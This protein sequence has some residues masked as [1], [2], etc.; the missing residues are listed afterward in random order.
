MTDLN[1]I[2]QHP[3]VLEV[4]GA[5]KGQPRN[6]CFDSGKVSKGDMFVA[7]QGT[8]VDGHKYI[9]SAIKS[10]AAFVVCE[11]FPESVHSGICYIRVKDSHE[12]LGILASEFYGNPSTE[13]KIVGVTGTNGKTTIASLLYEIFRSLGYCAGLISTIKVSVNGKDRD[14]SH[15]TPDSLQLQSSLREMA[16]SGCEYVFMEVSSHAIHQKRIAGLSFEG[17]IF[18]NLSHEHLDYHKD[19]AGYRDAK[20]AFFDQLGESSFALSNKDDKNGEW[21]L[22]N[23]SAR[24]YTYSLKADSDF[25]G[26]ITE[27]HLEGNL[28]EIDGNEVW[29]RLPGR[30]NGANLLAVYGAA[31]LLGIENNE[32]LRALSEVSPVEGRFE[33]IISDKGPKAIVDYAHTPDALE[34]VLKTIIEINPAERIIT[35]VGAGGNRDKTK[36][37]EMAKIAAELSY[38]LILTSDNPR[39]EDPHEIIEDMK[40]GLDP[41]LMKKVLAIADRREAIKTACSFA[42]KDDI[43]LIAGKGHESYQEIKGQKHHFDDKEIIREFLNI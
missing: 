20:K 24:K 13:L 7:V 38:R 25:K 15:T 10:G 19:F 17:G 4:K 1:K 31:I 37:P 23:T 22:Q 16:D 33:I 2:L 36:R 29:T 3:M 30:F 9:E 18:T 28:M 41:V 11:K 14:A 39:D 6:I 32:I 40:K 12:S 27:M 42:E 26:R 21:M 34:N 35:V 5:C 43:I 8:R